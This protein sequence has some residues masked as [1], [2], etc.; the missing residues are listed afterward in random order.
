MSDALLLCE[1]GWE[2]LFLKSGVRVF[3][4]EIETGDHNKLILMVACLNFLQ[5]PRNSLTKVTTT[6]TVEMFLNWRPSVLTGW[7]H[8]TSAASTAWMPSQ[9]KRKKKTIWSSSWSRRTTCL[10]S[11]LRVACVISMVRLEFEVFLSE[12]WTNYC[13]SRLRRS[14]GLAPKEP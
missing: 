5:V 13:S 11:G 1:A 14:Q 7:K 12:P 3:I 8:V 10:T 2:I 6:S 9:L 4:D